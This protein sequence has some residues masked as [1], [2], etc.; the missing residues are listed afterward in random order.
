MS[1]WTGDE[2]RWYSWA[3]RPGPSRSISVIEPANVPEPPSNARRV[4]FGFSRVLYSAP[5]T[6][7]AMPLRWEGDD[8]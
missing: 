5:T 7:L 4:P 2:W 1:Y 3:H 8:S 6:E